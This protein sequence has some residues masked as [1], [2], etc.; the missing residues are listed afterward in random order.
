VNHRVK[1]YVLQVCSL[2][3]KQYIYRIKW[4]KLT[5]IL[6]VHFIFIPH[7]VHLKHEQ[8]EEIRR[9]RSFSSVREL[10]W[11]EK[12]R[13]YVLLI[14]L[15]NIF[16]SLSFVVSKSWPSWFVRSHTIYVLK[17]SDTD[18][19]PKI[20]AIPCAPCP[21]HGFTLPN[22]PTHSVSILRLKIRCALFHFIELFSCRATAE[23]MI[24]T[25]NTKEEATD[26]SDSTR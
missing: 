23:Q 14:T 3:C 18:L 7:H 10:A 5:F 21:I 4:R 24:N 8:D 13:V 25:P 19:T 9:R 12:D 15:L 17:K 20:Q 22:F 1:Y 2:T 11:Q 26:C 16:P 6:G